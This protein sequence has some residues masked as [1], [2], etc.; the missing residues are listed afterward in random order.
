MDVVSVHR[1]AFLD[2]E[3]QPLW[4]P[5]RFDPDPAALAIHRANFFKQMS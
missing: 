4:R 1:A 2:L 5:I 3:G